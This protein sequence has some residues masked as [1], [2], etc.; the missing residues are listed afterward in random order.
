ML[1]FHKVIDATFVIYKNDNKSQ[2][3]QDIIKPMEE[4]KCQPLT[5][6]VCSKFG[7]NVRQLT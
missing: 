7:Y 3:K 1:V 6:P 5:I 4:K 2:E